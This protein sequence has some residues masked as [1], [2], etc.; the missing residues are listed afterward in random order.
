[1]NAKNLSI[2]LLSA[3]VISVALAADPKRETVPGTP[4]AAPA[5]ADAAGWGRGEPGRPNA[6]LLKR[7]DKNGDGQLDETERAA[8]REAVGKM[9]ARR[10]DGPL[11]EEVLRR[12]DKDGDGK[13]NDAERADFEQAREGMRKKAGAGD[14]K[15]RERLI[16]QFDRDGDGKLN[17][18]EEAAARAEMQ[19]RRAAGKKPA[20]T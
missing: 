5:P 9:D 6:A 3:T 7:F 1:M 4:L 11:R 2:S 19:K 13:L 10:P 17:A 20:G 18:D 8:A 14:G 16:K 15:L 12:F